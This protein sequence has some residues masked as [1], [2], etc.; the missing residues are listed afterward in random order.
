MAGYHELVHAGTLEQRAEALFARAA[1]CRLCPR[2]CGVRRL[3]G[4]RGRCGAGHGVRVAKAVAHFGEEPPITGARGSGAIFFA[5]CNLSCCFCQNWQIS[6][7]AL[8]EDM[9]VEQLADAMCGLQKQGCHNINLV[10]AAHYMPW[11]VAA[12]GLAAGHGLTVP[13]VYNSNGYED[14]GMLRLLEGI[15]DIYL[16]DAKYADSAPAE[17]YSGARDYAAVNAG[18]LAEMFRQAGY[19]ELDGDGLA[20][21]GLIVRHLVLPGGLAGTETVLRGLRR[22][23]GRFLA[24][25]LMGQYRPCYRADDYPELRARTSRQDYGAAVALLEELGFENG[26]TQQQAELDGAFV[27]DFKKKDAWN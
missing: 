3:Q 11:I 21:K 10:S 8:G 27:P 5:H 25:S 19:L 22:R 1:S 4:E 9:T 24:V 18:A 23:F 16:P 15:I 20:Q 17:A 13:L 14:A 26:W 6:H 12:V 2:Q 7:E